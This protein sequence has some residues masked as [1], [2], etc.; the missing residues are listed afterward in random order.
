MILNADVES[1]ENDLFLWQFNG[2]H[3]SD[4]AVLP[5]PDICGRIF[6]TEFERI[7][8]RGGN[9]CRL[10]CRK[11]GGGGVEMFPGNRL[12]TINSVSG[13]HAIEVDLQDALLAPEKLD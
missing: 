11:F 5:V 8:Q 13:F 6:G 10:R 12:D 9:Q 2:S 4:N 1:K 3:L 7:G